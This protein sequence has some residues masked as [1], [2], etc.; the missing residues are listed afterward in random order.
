MKN[1]YVKLTLHDNDYYYEL[2]YLCGLVKQMILDYPKLF[3]SSDIPDILS[4]PKRRKWLVDSIRQT[5]DSICQ[6]SYC[7]KNRNE[8]KGYKG[9]SKTLSVT[10]HNNSEFPTSN[11][12]EDWF[13]NL[14]SITYKGHY[15]CI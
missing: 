5:F 12:K 2:S 15:F 1:L 4:D 7:F 10:F 6:I 3:E 11:N 13:I 9:L 14:S 8:C